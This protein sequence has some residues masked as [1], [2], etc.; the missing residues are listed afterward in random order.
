MKKRIKPT[1]NGLSQ[2]GREFQY[3]TGQCEAGFSNNGII[4]SEAGFPIVYQM[5]LSFFLRKEKCRGKPGNFGDVVAQLAKAT[6]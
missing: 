6:G 5:F 3:S 1:S 4:N 2:G